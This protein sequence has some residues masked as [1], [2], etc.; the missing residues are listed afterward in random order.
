[1]VTKPISRRSLFKNA[2]WGG[3]GGALALDSMGGLS[4]L[5]ALNPG[6]IL[7]P[8]GQ[9]LDSYLLM[10]QALKGD[11]SW[12]RWQEA[13]A[14]EVS[15][16]SEEW[17]VVTVKVFD[18]VHTPLIFAL[19]QMSGNNVTT[20]TLA[21]DVHPATKRAGGTRAYL[22]G[23]GVKN[24]CQIERMKNLRFNDFFG[25]R[26]YYGTYDGV[27]NGNKL[28][29]N[30][31]VGAFPADVALQVGLGVNRD[32]S[33]AVHQMTSTKLR[34]DQ[35]D[36]AFFIEDKGLIKSPLGITCF[37]MGDKYDANGGEDTNVV[38]NNAT[39]G[40][41][42]VGRTV[43]AY[44]N[45]IK[46][47][48]SSGFFDGTPLDQNLTLMFDKLVAQN[49]ERRK[50]LYNNR[51]KIRAAVDKF[52]EI[53]TVEK[54]IFP[55]VDASI[56]NTQCRGSTVAAP[57]SQEFLAQCSY[58][59]NAL[60]IPGLPMRNFS[61]FL[62]LN[63]LDGANFDDPVNAALGTSFGG[64]NY[65]EGMRQLAMGLNVLA[66]SIAARDGK[67]AKKVIVVVVSDGGRD[68]GMGD[69]QVGVSMVMGP[70]GAGMLDD[71]LSAPMSAL[72][73]PD[74]DILFFKGTGD[75]VNL[76]WDGTDGTRGL[77]D[78]AGAVTANMPANIG[79]IQNG[80]IDFL[81]SRLNK[82]VRTPAL[83]SFVKLKRG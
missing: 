60:D 4:L 41:A 26:L 20:A 58:V 12:W 45:N 6:R 64:L 63:D 47:S 33:I 32:T 22:S 68:E 65:V 27:E 69:G 83:G 28:G 7:D 5:G 66:N 82:S 76:P 78:S 49:P 75:A 56:G 81:E 44:V 39:R 74:P 9:T 8:R 80:V 61:L 34:K 42:V 17:A 21:D 50:G 73:S 72:N 67:P 14:Q 57:A 29:L 38:Y 15:P 19:G 3:V 24:L 51:E 52:N 1:M 43:N 77:R 36:L 18:N 53:A 54:T 46:Q 11:A 79:D 25:K 59:A 10:Q 23:Q 70:K 55:S 37:M 31:P 48:L 13:M 62:N 30:V 40:M 2:L 16:A 71:A 35:P